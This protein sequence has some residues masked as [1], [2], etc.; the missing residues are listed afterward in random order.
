MWG[1]AVLILVLG[2][3]PPVLRYLVFW[4]EDQWQVD[5]EV[6]RQ[7][8]LSLL[9][10]CAALQRP[11]VQPAPL[12]APAPPPAPAPS[13]PGPAAAPTVSLAYEQRRLAATAFQ[14]EI[15]V[16]RILKAFK[17]KYAHFATG[18]S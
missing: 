11:P 18:A 12:P 4:P 15:E 13:P 1:L 7:A 16:E 2:A 6:Y 14:R 5:V 8:A 17:L 9:A 3:L 10:G